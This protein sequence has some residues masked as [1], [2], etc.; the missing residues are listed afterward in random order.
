MTVM[1]NRVWKD[2]LSL[3]QANYKEVPNSI[4]AVSS[5][6]KAYAT[7]NPGRSEELYKR[8]VEIDP[9]YWP[10]Y[11]SL[12]L[13]DRSREKAREAEAL[14]RN[15]LTL[16][17]AEIAESG[18]QEPSMFRSQMTGALALTKFSQGDADSAERLY[19][20]AIN[21][22]PLNPQ[23]YTMLANYYRERDP[24]KAIATLEQLVAAYPGHRE[25]LEQVATLLLEEQ[26]YDEAI[27]YLEQ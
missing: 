12:A 2:D 7:N 4:R 19:R 21:L 11:Y 22:N 10:A 9:A 17:D 8:C 24:A 15:G 6:A 26:R 16:S 25:P 13:L 1:R 23:P 3:W 20:E 18:G 27:V 5:L 14:I